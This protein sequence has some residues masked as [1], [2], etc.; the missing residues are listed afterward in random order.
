MTGTRRPTNVTDRMDLVVCRNVLIYFRERRSSGSVDRFHDSLVDSGWLVVGHA[1]PSQEIFHR[2]Q[3]TNYPGTIVYRKSRTEQQGKPVEPLKRVEPAVPPSAGFGTQARWGNPQSAI[4]N[5]QSAIWPRAAVA[6]GWG[7]SR[8][9]GRWLS[10]G[11]VE[12]RV[13]AVRGGSFW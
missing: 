6:A 10:G 13:R 12:G 5:P 8:L 4:R 3:V 9:L 2:Y 7:A 11:P 1:E